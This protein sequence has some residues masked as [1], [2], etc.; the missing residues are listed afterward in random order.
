MGKAVAVFP[1]C[2]LN[3]CHNRQQKVV[4]VLWQN[5]LRRDHIKATTFDVRVVGL[6]RAPVLIRNL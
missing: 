3:G 6:V 1:N 2:S 4:A 5:L